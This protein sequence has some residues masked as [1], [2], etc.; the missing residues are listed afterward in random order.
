M[1]ALILAVAFMEM[2]IIIGIYGQSFAVLL[3][4][5]LEYQLGII[6]LKEIQETYESQDFTH[7]G[8]IYRQVSK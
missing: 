8:I 5:L 2:R 4:Q 1:D 7:L 6:Q 3:Q